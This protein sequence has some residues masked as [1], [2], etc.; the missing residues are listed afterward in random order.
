MNGDIPHLVTIDHF[1]RHRPLVLV[2]PFFGGIDMEIDTGIGTAYNHEDEIV[3]LVHAFVTWVNMST[4]QFLSFG[5]GDGTSP[6][7]GLRRWEFSSSHLGKLIGG[8]SIL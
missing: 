3:P 4:D 7:G 8:A 5:L 1:E 6:T 2:E